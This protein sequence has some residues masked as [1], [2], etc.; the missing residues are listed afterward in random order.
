MKKN[1]LKG[2]KKFKANKPEKKKDASTEEIKYS[3]RNKKKM[4]IN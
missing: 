1:N 3:N 2:R 4:I